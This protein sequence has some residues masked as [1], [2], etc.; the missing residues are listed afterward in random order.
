M[1]VLYLP[2]DIFPLSL[3]KFLVVS[4]DCS[5][6]EGVGDVLS[7]GG[8]PIYL[9]SEGLGSISRRS[10]AASTS[11]FCANL[12]LRRL[13][14]C[15]KY[16]SRPEISGKLSNRLRYLGGGRIGASPS[17]PLH[18]PQPFFFPLGPPVCI[19]GIPDT[20][21]AWGLKEDAD[22]IAILSRADL[23]GPHG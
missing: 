16:L 2:A 7:W 12:I 19:N 15:Q 21:W 9:P 11:L 14:A 3:D 23:T 4:S 10:G 18:T 6:E 5:C 1:S 17:L 22:G 8:V 13:L 20:L